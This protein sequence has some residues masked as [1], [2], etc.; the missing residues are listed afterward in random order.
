MVTRSAVDWGS[1]VG[2]FAFA[3]ACF[4]PL[5]L[6]IRAEAVSTRVAGMRV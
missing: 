4:A 5:T 6:F 1:V 3:A 2:V